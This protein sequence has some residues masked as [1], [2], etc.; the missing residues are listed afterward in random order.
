MFNASLNRMP[1]DLKGKFTQ[2]PHPNHPSLASLF[3]RCYELYEIDP[4]KAPTIFFIQE[5]DHE[6]GGDLVIKYAMKVIG[7]GRDKTTIHGSGFRIG[8]T[9]EEGKTAVLKGM[10]MKGSSELGLLNQNGLSFLCDSMTFTQCGSE[11]V[12][13]SNTKGRLINCVITQCKY[14]GIFSG[15]NA[16]I[17][18]EGDQ[19]KV[20]GNG[21]RG[22]SGHYGLNAFSTSSR[23]HL[24]FPLTQE[25]VST[26]N[27]G[28]G[29][30]RDHGIQT[31]DSFAPFC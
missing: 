26:N 15:S 9:K 23:I 14:S 18:L 30:Y 11:G 7:A 6:A 28:G 8:G 29:N 27:L 5:G 19:T 3:A 16:L 2:H 10:T 12:V 24:L 1:K 17:E 13:A 31:V 22:Y 21:T 25:S 20:D 4:T